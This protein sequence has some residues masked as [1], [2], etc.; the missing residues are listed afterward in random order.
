MGS[1]RFVAAVGMLLMFCQPIYAILHTF[2]YKSWF[3]NTSKRFWMYWVGEDRS[4]TDVRDTYELQQ[5]LGP[6]YTA[7]ITDG[8]HHADTLQHLASS[9][10]MV[11]LTDRNA[12]WLHSRVRDKYKALEEKKDMMKSQ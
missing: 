7:P 2:P 3:P 1:L 6:G 8:V 4:E 10:R 12:R 5:E 9:N 11:L